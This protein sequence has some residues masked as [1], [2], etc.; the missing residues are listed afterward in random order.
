MCLLET[1]NK[2]FDFG[3]PYLIG[4]YVCLTLKI[5]F[6]TTLAIA[7]NVHKSVAH[8]FAKYTFV[9]KLF[10]SFIF[11]VAPLRSLSYFLCSGVHSVAYA[12]PKVKLVTTAVDPEINDNFYILPGIGQHL[13]III[14]LCPSYAILRET[15]F[16][17]HTT[18]LTG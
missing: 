18:T 13:F 17:S 3:S 4:K 6:F 5:V 16:S 12:F 1:T 15:P 2:Q 7:Y 9:V 14:R 8:A 10:F 11:L